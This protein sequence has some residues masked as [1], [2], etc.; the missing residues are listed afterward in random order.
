MHIQS[1]LMGKAGSYHSATDML[2]LTF[3]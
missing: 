2:S 3:I 1:V